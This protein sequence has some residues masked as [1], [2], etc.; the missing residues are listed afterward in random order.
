V[1]RSLNRGELNMMETSIPRRLTKAAL[2]E[3]GWTDA[4]IRRFLPEPDEQKINPRYRSAAPMLL[5][6]LDRVETIETSSE[7]QEWKAKSSAH[8]AEMLKVADVQ[9]Q[10]LLDE[11]SGYPVRLRKMPK[12][13][14]TLAACRHYNDRQN[15]GYGVPLIVSGDNLASPDSDEAFLDRI[16][17]NYL[18]HHCSNYETELEKT[19]GKVGVQQAYEVI[20][21]RVLQAIAEA[22]PKLKAECERQ[23]LK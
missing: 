23:K 2:K 21:N 19:F 11:I 14:L 7:W 16:T 13:K 17:V 9:R 1:L 18:R 15:D 22:Y 8:S 12:E 4:G 10:Q 6:N 20:R 3:R 5:W